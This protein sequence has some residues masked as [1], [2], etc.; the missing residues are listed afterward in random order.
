MEYLPKAKKEA[1]ILG[2]NY[3]FTGKPCKHGHLSKR[4]ISGYC[5]ECSLENYKKRYAENKKPHIERVLKWQKENPEKYRE[6]QLK[7]RFSEKGKI[8]ARK[9]ALIRF[10]RERAVEGKFTKHDIDSLLVKQ[11]GQCKYC[12][13]DICGNYH[14]DHIHPISKGGS[15]WPDNLQLTCPSCNSKKSNKSHDEFIA[16]QKRN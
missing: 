12:F 8:S 9:A 1:Q 2:V 7:R 6:Q 16:L 14:I 15:N 11:H 13:A 3:Y 5:Y 10:H 4:H